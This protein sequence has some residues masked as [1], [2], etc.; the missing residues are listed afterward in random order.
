LI[1][2]NIQRSEIIDDDNEW[3][4]KVGKAAYD[5]VCNCINNDF[6]VKSS[7]PALLE[8]FELAIEQYLDTM[9]SKLKPQFQQMLADI[10]ARQENLERSQ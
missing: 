1:Q 3:I 8:C 2:S 10:K 9:P 5:L 6:L 7:G 4:E